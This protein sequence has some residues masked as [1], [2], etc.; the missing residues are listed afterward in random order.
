[1][2]RRDVVAGA[3]AL[4]AS[5]GAAGGARAQT[6]ERVQ[7]LGAPL[8]IGWDR[9]GIPHVEAGSVADAFFGQGY[10][11]ATLRLWQM[12]LAR[13]RTL[14]RLAAVFGPA[15]VPF[16]VAARTVRFRGDVAAEWAHHDPRVKPLAEAWVAGVNARIAAVEAD[17]A[18]LP[19]GIHGHGHAARALGGRGPDPDAG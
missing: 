17:P 12:D 11:V 19:P 15:F 2:R 4:G 5:L 13:R 3:A 1:M 8:S 16:D 14:G 7:G 18:L 6:V 10:A 9:W